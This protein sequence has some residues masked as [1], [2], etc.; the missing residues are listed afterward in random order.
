MVWLTLM[1]PLAPPYVMSLEPYVAGL[2]IDSNSPI[3]HW[4][5]LA[6]NENCFGAAASVKEAIARSVHL[7][8]YYP[9]FD[10]GKVVDALIQH[11]NPFHVTSKNIV[12][13]N[14]SSELI[15]ALVRGLLLP[16]EA[17]IIGWPSFIMYYSAC[18]AQGRRIEKIPLQKDFSYDFSAMLLAIKNPANNIKLVFLGN[19]NNPTGRYEKKS[20]L[21]RFISELPE[22]VV[23]VFDEAY[24]EYVVEDDYLNG[25]SLALNRPRTIVLRTFSKIHALAGVRLGYAIGDASII[26]VLLRVLDPFNVN[27]LAQIAGIEAL[28]AKEH[29]IES[30]EHNIMAKDVLTAGLSNLGFSVTKSACNFVLAKKNLLHPPIKTICHELFQKG[31]IVRPLFNYGLD[32]YIRISVGTLPEINQAI[33]ALKSL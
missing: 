15:V 4:A 3:K 18:I 14:G 11:L 6:S 30:I 31:V 5:K 1:Q 8:H 24:H 17:V 2:P 19:P 20:S 13:G 25:L 29:T 22:D 26:D 23:V 9:N 33:E 21:I 32:T 7:I 12:L 28:K 16:H 10:R 27:S